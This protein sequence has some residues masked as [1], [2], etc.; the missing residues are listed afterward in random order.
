MYLPSLLVEIYS[1]KNDF[2][3][4]KGLAA[5]KSKWEVMKVKKIKHLPLDSSLHFERGSDIRK[6]N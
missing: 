5:L 1:A 2:A 6:A 4:P 3:F